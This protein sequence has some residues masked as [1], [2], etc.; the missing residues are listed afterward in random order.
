MPRTRKLLYYSALTSLLLSGCMAPT[1]S[2]VSAPVTEGRMTLYFANESQQCSFNAITRTVPF[3]DEPRSDSNHCKSLRNGGYFL[4]R[5]FPSATRLWLIN[6]RDKPGQVPSAPKNCVQDPN[7]AL[8]W[9][10]LRTIKQPTNT[11]EKIRIEDLKT[12]QDG[13]VVTAGLRLIGRYKNPNT[14][15]VEPETINCLII[16]VSP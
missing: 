9:W 11:P 2:R 5:D 16:E 6:G 14:N 13:Q 7:L 12:L 3:P 10:E 8:N 4:L 1:Q 15:P